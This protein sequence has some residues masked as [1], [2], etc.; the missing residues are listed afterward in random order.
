M[1]RGPESTR[2]TPPPRASHHSTSWASPG[3]STSHGALR[4]ARVFPGS[5]LGAWTPLTLSFDQRSH[6]NRWVLMCNCLVPSH[7]HWQV[8]VVSLFLSLPFFFH[9]FIWLIWG[10]YTLLCFPGLLITKE[11][12]KHWGRKGSETLL[13]WPS[14]PGPLSTCK[15]SFRF[16][17]NILFPSWS[18]HGE[19]THC[20]SL[21]LVVGLLLCKVLKH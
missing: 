14:R 17:A 18:I 20:K 12:R 21:S 8:N 13:P 3:P 9:P 5:T 10:W 2:Q 11:E 4:T 6:F 15:C 7:M 1:D 16:N 19:A